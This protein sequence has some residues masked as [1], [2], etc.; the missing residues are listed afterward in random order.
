M[1][2]HA[3]HCGLAA[4]LSLSGVACAA[5][6]DQRQLITAQTIYRIRDGRIAE[7]WHLEDN[8]TFLRQLA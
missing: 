7:N 8:L 5:G 2:S 3:L 4:A 6:T 1:S